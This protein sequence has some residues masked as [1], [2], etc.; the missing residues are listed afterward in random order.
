MSIKVKQSELPHGVTLQY[1]EQGEKSGIPILFLHGLSD[2]LE[3]MVIQVV[4]RKV[5]VF[6]ILRR[7]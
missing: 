7:M 3:V 2:S 5:I 1:A 6:E 4:Q